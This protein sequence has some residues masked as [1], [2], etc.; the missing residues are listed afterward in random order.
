MADV[1]TAVSPLRRRM[2]DDMKL[3]NMAAG[4]HRTYVRSLAGWA[5]ADG[6]GRPTGDVWFNAS[7]PYSKAVE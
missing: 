3:R 2:I 7:I 5:G 1:T 6:F 4:T